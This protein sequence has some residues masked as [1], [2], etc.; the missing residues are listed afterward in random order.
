MPAAQATTIPIE[1]G[2]KGPTAVVEGN[3]VPISITPTTN[4]TRSPSRTGIRDP[5]R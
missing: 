2:L 3:I 5:T 1:A 4:T